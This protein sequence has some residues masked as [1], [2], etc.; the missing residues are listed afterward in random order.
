MGNCSCLERPKKVTA[1]D[2]DDN[3]NHG[4]KVKIRMAKG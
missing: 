3:N 2:D 1:W 4:M